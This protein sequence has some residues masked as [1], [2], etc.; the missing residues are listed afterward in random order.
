[1]P[2]DFV[3]SKTFTGARPG[4]AFKS[5]AHGIGYYRDVAPGTGASTGNAASASAYYHFSSHG[6]RHGRA[7]K[8][9][10]YDVE[11]EL[12]RLDEEERAEEDREAEEDKENGE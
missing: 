1:M 11:A 7:S 6:Q 5:G 2:P 10:N 12:K 3:S 8:W 4:Y 9:E